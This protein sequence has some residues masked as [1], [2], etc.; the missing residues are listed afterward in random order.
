MSK[1]KEKM[2]KFE[3]LGSTISSNKS[4]NITYLILLKIGNKDT[5]DRITA[6]H[7]PNTFKLGKNLQV[8]ASW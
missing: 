3:K 7:I 1:T 6:T 8:L 5:V 4:L 2:I